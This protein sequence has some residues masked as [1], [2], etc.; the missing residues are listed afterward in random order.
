MAQSTTEELQAE[1]ARA[2]EAEKEIQQEIESIREDVS[3]Q[4]ESAEHLLRMFRKL[5]QRVDII[6]KRHEETM[7]E[8]IKL[9][10]TLRVKDQEIADKDAE[11]D[12]LKKQLAALQARDTSSSS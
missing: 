8:N 11:I 12:A 7:S 9:R 4:V 5:L 1:L 3:V 10:A 2:E 6:S